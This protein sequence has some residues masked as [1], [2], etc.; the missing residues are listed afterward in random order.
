MIVPL[1]GGAAV[2]KAAMDSAEA[3]CAC[4]TLRIDVG[5][6][7]QGP[8]GNMIADAQRAAT[9]ADVA[10]IT[11]GGIRTS[12]PA[13]PVTY[14]MLYAVQPFDNRMVR[15]T[16]TGRDLRRLLEQ[17]PG[18]AHVSGVRMSF[19]PARPSERRIVEVSR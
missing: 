3:R 15:V 6:Q 9:S 16:I 19:D 17:V 5:D 18:A 10:I 7:M 11:N 8:L 12:L 14:G 1:L 2:L 13:G 4:P